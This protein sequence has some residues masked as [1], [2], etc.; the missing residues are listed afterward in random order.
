[1]SSR[2]TPCI[3]CRHQKVKCIPSPDRTTSKCARCCRKGLVCEFLVAATSQVPTTPT[4]TGYYPYRQTQ[5]QF[6][7]DSKSTPSTPTVPLVPASAPSL[8]YTG[9][10]PLNSRPRYSHGAPY[11]ALALDANF[12]TEIHPSRHAYMPSAHG[13]SS[14]AYPGMPNCPFAWNQTTN[15]PYAYLP[16]PKIS[17]R[18]AARKTQINMEV[19]AE[20]EEGSYS[21]RGQY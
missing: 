13:H 3:N 4:L 5:P 14:T 9:P 7:S 17:G 16:I 11:P 20:S 10:P 2:T 12:G 21:Y 15:N 19:D 18:S 1:M 8:P 6:D